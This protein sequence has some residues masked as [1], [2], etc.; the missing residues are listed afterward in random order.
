[1]LDGTDESSGQVLS[2][3]AAAAAAAATVL[4]PPSDQIA[5]VA[6]LSN[7]SRDLVS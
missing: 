3:A 1:M 7:N 5:G 6:P 4:P 2:A